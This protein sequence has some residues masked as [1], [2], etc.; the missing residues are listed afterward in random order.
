[1]NT[2]MQEAWDNVTNSLDALESMIKGLEPKG[3]DAIETV[4]LA[5]YK[6]S[7]IQTMAD[8]LSTEIDDIIGG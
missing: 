1:M 2:T 6:L 8:S 7:R 3:S 5:K 4:T